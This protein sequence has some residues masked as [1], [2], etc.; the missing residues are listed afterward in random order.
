SAIISARPQACPAGPTQSFRP[1]VRLSSRTCG[2]CPSPRRRG[3][4]ILIP[5]AASASRYPARRCARLGSVPRPF[6]VLL[7]LSACGCSG[8]ATNNTPATPSRVV[9][10]FEQVPPGA[11]LAAPVVDGERVYAAA[12]Q[13]AGL[14]RYGA[15]YALDRQTGKVLWKFDGGGEM[16]HMYS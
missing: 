7:F 1:Q 11:V 16:Q 8:K 10:T 15:I 12:I 4:D 2:R 14:D 3:A 13:D 5:P 9:W 6:F